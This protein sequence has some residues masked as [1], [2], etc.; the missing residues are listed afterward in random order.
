SVGPLDDLLPVG[1][2]LEHVQVP[3]DGLLVEDRIR[4]SIDE[5]RETAA[6]SQVQITAPPVLVE[7]LPG[8]AVDLDE[9]ARLG[10]EGLL[11]GQVAEGARPEW[12]GPQP[13][14]G[15]AGCREGEYEG[16]DAARRG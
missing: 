12:I 10:W 15:Q 11:D 5:H 1:L 7:H 13:P 3:P 2:H 4:P 14:C 8:K 9:I 16:Q 6:G